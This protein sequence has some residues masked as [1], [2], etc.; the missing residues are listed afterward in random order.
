MKSVFVMKSLHNLLEQ[1]RSLFG[2]LIDQTGQIWTITTSARQDVARRLKHGV[3]D[4][5]AHC[6]PS[7]LSADETTWNKVSAWN[8]TTVKRL[9][10]QWFIRWKNRIYKYR[11]PTRSLETRGSPLWSVRIENHSRWNGHSKSTGKYDH[12]WLTSNCV[13]R[14]PWP[15][16]WL[17]EA[18]R[19]RWAT[20][21]D[22]FS[23][24]WRLCRPWFLLDWVCPLLMVAKGRHL[25]R[26]VIN[27][28][29]ENAQWQLALAARKPRVSPLDRILHL[30]GR[31]PHQ[32]QSNGLRRMHDRL[33]RIANSSIDEWTVPL[34]SR[35]PLARHTHNWFVI[36]LA[37]S[38]HFWRL[39]QRIYRIYTDSK[40]PPPVG[41][42]VIWSG[43]TRS[44]IS[45]R[46][47]LARSYS[48][49]MKRVVVA[50]FTGLR[51]LWIYIWTQSYHS[52]SK[53]VASFWL[54][55]TCYQL[56]ARTRPRIKVT[57]CT[58]ATQPPAFPGKNCSHCNH[59]NFMISLITIFSAP[60]YL[61]MYQNKAAIL[62]YEDNVMNIRQF[63]CSPHPYWL[64]N[65]MDVFTWS[66]PFV[67]EKV[68]TRT[69]LSSI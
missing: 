31:V 47:R 28:K 5:G 20:G 38:F 49:S 61:D 60:N 65:F 33:W 12:S 36:S 58:N 67:G 26:M 17:V 27:G 8:A 53:P 25:A 48:P 30:Q 44:R 15:V 41:H 2:Y 16:L 43:V 3:A 39:V 22:Q 51:F 7:S 52:V 54:K 29:I 21:K 13:R 19:G 68:S 66:L 45:A 24:S 56:F 14:C 55:T 10:F 57:K 42:C 40:S 59:L 9:Q 62:K 50:T 37:S 64:P 34:C 23:I 11:N 32:V 46:S 4:K 63:N 69:S 35:W 6:W 18:V 1:Q